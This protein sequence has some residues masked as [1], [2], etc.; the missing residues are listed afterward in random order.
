M[1]LHEKLNKYF[2]ENG[3]QRKWFAKKIGISP[4]LFYTMLCGQQKI[5]ARLW[6]KLIELTGGY[7]TLGDILTQEFKNI[8]YL[9]V[10]QGSDYDL[11]EVKVKNIIKKQ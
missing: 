8:D 1:Q 10:T 5:T 2:E 4:Q 11:C 6:K 9:S 3:I 7:I